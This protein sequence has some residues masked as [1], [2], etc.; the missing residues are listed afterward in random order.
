V[1]GPRLPRVIGHR[2]AASLAPENTLAAMRAA[3]DAGALWVE[4]DVRLSRDREC[5]VIH[6]ATLQRTAG[7]RAAV[8]RLPLEA[9]RHCDA[10]GWF[11]PNFAGEPVPSLAEA[12]ALLSELGM[13]ANVE[14]KSC[15]RRNEALVDAVLRTLAAVCRAGVP[16]VLVSSF[17]PALLRAVRRR[18]R[19]LPLGLLLER[20]WRRDWRAV[21]RELGCFSVHCADR[22]LRAGDVAGIKS[23]GYAAVVYTVDDPERARELLSWGV[24]SMICDGPGRILAAIGD[25]APRAG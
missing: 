17:S 23:A 5:V 24:D 4:F 7:R 15:G 18:D 2:G 25:S 22:D 16:P 9:L 1:S 3:H 12:L 20:R 13:G 8:S 19:V 14:L 6:D 10:G 21:A 11:S